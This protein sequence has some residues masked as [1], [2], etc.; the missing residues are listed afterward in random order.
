ML[1]PE[2]TWH[3]N[4]HHTYMCTHFIAPQLISSHETIRKHLLLPRHASIMPVESQLHLFCLQNEIADMHSNLQ[5]WCESTSYTLPRHQE[6]HVRSVAKRTTSKRGSSS[7][8]GSHTSWEGCA[9]T[10]CLVMF[11]WS[12]KGLLVHTPSWS[13]LLHSRLPRENTL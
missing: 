1:L 5:S 3:Q 7:V 10:A 13:S 12:K 8:W 6:E 2:Q 4:S 11:A 9:S